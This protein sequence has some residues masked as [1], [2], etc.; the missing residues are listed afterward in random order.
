MAGRLPPVHPNRPTASQNL[1]VLA[2]EQVVETDFSKGV[3]RNCQALRHL[4]LG[5]RLLWAM[6]QG[7]GCPDPSTK[8]DLTPPLLP[9][10]APGTSGSNSALNLGILCLSPN[11]AQTEAMGQ[12][13][14]TWDGMR[15]SG[16]KGTRS[17][18]FSSGS[19]EA[20]STF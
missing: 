9:P 16:T 18:P 19:L 8:P 1:N 17:S 10:R 20:L 14:N 3:R 12:T 15:L 11:D 5:G 7:L 4:A 2:P 6:C 13:F